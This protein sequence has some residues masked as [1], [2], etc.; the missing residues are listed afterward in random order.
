MK[1]EIGDRVRMSEALKTQLRGGCVPGKHQ[2]DLL[3]DNDESCMKCSLGHLKEFGN[4][5]GLVLGL[6]DYN[7][8]KPGAESYDPRKVGPEVDVRWLPSRLRYAYDPALLE[9]VGKLKVGKIYMLRGGHI[10]RY[11]GPW[12]GRGPCLAF[13]TPK[14]ELAGNLDHI[15]GY[16]ASES[17]VLYQFEKKNI[18]SLLGRIEDLKARAM[19]FAAEEIENVVKELERDG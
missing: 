6:T 16:S 7:N 10:L 8:C 18:P 11:H 19:F 3:E 9:L 1:L 12:G 17:E 5:E 13:Q 14:E 4:C 2:G 15:V